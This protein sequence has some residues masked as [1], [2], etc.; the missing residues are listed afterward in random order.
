M[1]GRKSE[2]GSIVWAGPN[3]R[4]WKQGNQFRSA[5][6]VGPWPSVVAGKMGRKTLD[7]AYRKRECKEELAIVR[8]GGCV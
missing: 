8:T 2:A 6:D 1:E 7:V 5:R 4:A 3:G